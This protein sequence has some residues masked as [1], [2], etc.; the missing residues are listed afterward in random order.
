V[1]TPS[2]STWH[3]T[4]DASGNGYWLVTSTG[5]VYA[6]GDAVDYGQPNPQVVP[7]T[8]AVRTTDGKGYWLLCANG[9]VAALGDARTSPLLWAK[10]VAS[11]PSP[12]S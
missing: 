1:S 6:F 12:P 8:A 7:V 9:A 2:P 4:I 11:T 5:H 10:S 3:P